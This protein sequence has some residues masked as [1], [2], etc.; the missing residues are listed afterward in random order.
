VGYLHEAMHNTNVTD[1]RSGSAVGG[2][3]K[4]MVAWLVLAAAAILAIKLI[5]GSII[6]LI[7]LLI[8]IV[9]VVLLIAAVIWAFKQL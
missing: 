7:T 9:G 2:F 1:E 4:K 8:T 5:F 6:G 3:F